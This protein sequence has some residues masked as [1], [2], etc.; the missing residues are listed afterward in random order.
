MHPP[1]W[2]FCFFDRIEKIPNGVIR[3]R[4]RQT[5]RLSISKTRGPLLCFNMEFHPTP[6]AFG[7]DQA[8]GMTPIAIHMTVGLRSA[9]ITEEHRDLVE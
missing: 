6:F 5:I 2:E 9:T 3:I 8:E 7:I 1:T 4:T